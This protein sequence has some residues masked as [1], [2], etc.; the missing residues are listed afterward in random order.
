VEEKD[1]ANKLAAA[2]QDT[3]I[4]KNIISGLTIGGFIGILFGYLLNTNIL[5]LDVISDLFTTIQIN[6]IIGGTLL[7]IIIGGLIGGFFA[8]SSTEN[9]NSDYIQE[10]GT[11]KQNIYNSKNVTLQFKEE[12]LDLAKKWIQTGEVK[13]YREYSTEEKSFTVPVKREELVI[14]KEILV[15]AT[16]EHKD[17]P[18]EVIRILLSEEQVKFVKHRVALEDVAIYKQKIESIEQIKETLKREEPRIK[19]SGSPEV[20][21]IYRYPDHGESDKDAP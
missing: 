6:E 9:I 17:V 2:H 13:I 4:T 10:S 5:I 12:Q 19:I 1:M 18:K 15:S 14:E 11:L 3:H 16:P 20:K 7:G 21:S 8:L